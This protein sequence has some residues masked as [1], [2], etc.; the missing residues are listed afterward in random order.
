MHSSEVLL[1]NTSAL[2]EAKKQIPFTKNLQFPYFTP[3]TLKKRIKKAGRNKPGLTF[4]IDLTI[5]VEKLFL[6][7]EFRSDRT[8][9]NSY[10]TTVCQP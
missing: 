3:L 8:G 10:F 1:I 4:Y 2:I 5:A 7:I 6:I 9:N